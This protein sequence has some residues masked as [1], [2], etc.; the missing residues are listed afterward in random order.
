MTEKHTVRFWIMFTIITLNSFSCRSLFPLHLFG[1]VGFYLAPSSAVCF[2]VFSFCL[3]YCV[4]GLFFAG[5]RF[6]VPP[7]FWCLLPVGKVGS[8][9]CLGFVVEETG[10]CVLMDE[11]GSCLL[12]AG[13]CPVVCFG[14]FVY[15]L[16]F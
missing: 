9:G 10:A 2:S 15:L 12:V 6:V 5:C 13:P 11:A 14:M 1:L 16:L 4:W 7:C 3:T 8:V